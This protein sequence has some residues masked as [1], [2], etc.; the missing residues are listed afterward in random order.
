LGNA[1]YTL[2][3][4]VVCDSCN[5]YFAREVEKP[6]L[7]A[8]PVKSLRFEQAI[9]SKRGK[10][11]QLPGIITPIGVPALVTRYSSGPIVGSIAVPEE[12]V[13]SFRELNQGLLIFQTPPGYPTG[14]VVSRFLAKVAIEAMAHRLLHYPGGPEHLVGEAALD[15]IRHHA[16]RGETPCWPFHVRLI[17]NRDKKWPDPSG[18][19]VQVVHE[20]DILKTDLDEWFLVLAIF[21]MEFTINIGGPEI[22]GYLK[23][24]AKHDHASPLYSGKNAHL[25]DPRDTDTGYR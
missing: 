7:E 18:S 24:L 4:G 11:P 2:P 3:P 12:A 9:P 1:L 13:P 10:I 23:W 21:G 15:L 25:A 6:F 17:Y 8:E 19:Y 20:F 14:S 16:R 5:N 22:D